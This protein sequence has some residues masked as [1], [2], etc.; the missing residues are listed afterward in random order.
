MRVKGAS[1][2]ATG[3]QIDAGGGP[4]KKLKSFYAD[5]VKTLNGIPSDFVCYCFF[6]HI[7]DKAQGMLR[8]SPSPYAAC[9]MAL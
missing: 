3:R 4:P 9:F 2:K 5:V 8:C 6:V 7:P 1:L